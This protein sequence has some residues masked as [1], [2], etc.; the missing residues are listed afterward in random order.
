ML[1]RFAFV[2]WGM[3]L[4]LTGCGS[5]VSA[6]LDTFSASDYDLS[7]DKSFTVLAV[8][9]GGSLEERAYLDVIKDKMISMGFTYDPQN[10][11]LW[12]TVSYRSSKR[13]VQKPSHVITTPKYI[14]GQTTTHS[15]FAGNT[16][17]TGTSQTSGT[18]TTESSSVGGG[19]EE[20]I[21]RAFRL[22][23]YDAKAS[24]EK[25]EAIQ[26][27]VGTVES[28]G[29]SSLRQVSQCLIHSLLDNY[30]Q[31]AKSDVYISGEDLRL[32]YQE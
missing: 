1:K 23:F 6:Q 32:C 31:P 9:E 22:F 30:P 7:A 5:V 27:W 4:C 15:G 29:N 2:L 20:V 11:D 8:Q 13:T 3:V 21:D 24:V 12:V 25:S 19:T 10:P 26:V 18:W 17:Y 16:A 14:P 28:S